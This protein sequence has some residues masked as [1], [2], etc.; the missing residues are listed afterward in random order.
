M[1]RIL[2]II[3]P[4]LFFCFLLVG[5][6]K[7]EFCNP[8]LFFE[9]F[10]ALSGNEIKT[11]SLVTT[12]SEG[13]RVYLFEAAQEDNIKTVI[14]LFSDS[15]GRIFECRVIISKLDENGKP[16]LLTS[17]AKEAFLKAAK[18]AACALDASLKENADE[19]FS[20]L[21]TLDEVSSTNTA[22]K[23]AE[24]KKQRYVF[25]SNEAVSSV[26]IYNAFL[27]PTEETR[28]PESKAA[29]DKTTNVRTQTVPHK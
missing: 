13:A 16:I 9:R 19:I 28:K 11:E 7:G 26:V 25:L 5:C 6:S 2:K 27:C 23:N 21:F 29:F 17:K 18:Q 12:E 10:S 14:K 3:L 15:Q 8:E 4:V 24:H 22:E 1:K 20:E